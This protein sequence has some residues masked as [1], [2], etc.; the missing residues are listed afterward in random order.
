MEIDAYDWSAIEDFSRSV[1]GCEHRLS[2]LVLAA[3]A[4]AAELY[5]GGLHAALLS[6]PGDRGVIETF[7]RKQL[8]ALEAGGM[9]VDAPEEEK[10]LWK[11]HQRERATNA[12][13]AGTSPKLLCRTEDEFWDCLQTLGDR[14][15]R[16]PRPTQE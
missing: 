7:V 13:G 3:H 16:Y 11:K 1:F 10:V 15:R 2:V 4:G 8:K 14:F 9:L 6:R 12:K 5:V